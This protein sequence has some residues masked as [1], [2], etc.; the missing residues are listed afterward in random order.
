MAEEEVDEQ[1]GEEVTEDQLPD[2]TTA[3]R[4]GAPMRIE[5]FNIDALTCLD[6]TANTPMHH[7]SQGAILHRFRIFEVTFRQV[8][9]LC[10]AWADKTNQQMGVAQRIAL[11]R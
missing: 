5:P 2:G 11:K 7:L 4:R 1:A 8:V 10:K 3:P 9:C 6:N